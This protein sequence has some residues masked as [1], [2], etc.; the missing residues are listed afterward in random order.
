MKQPS[1]RTHA[2]DLCSQNTN[3]ADLLFQKANGV[4][5]DVQQTQTQSCF[6]SQGKGKGRNEFQPSPC[7]ALSSLSSTGL[8]QRNL[9]RSEP[10]LKH[11]MVKD[12]AQAGSLT[13]HLSG[14]KHRATGRNSKSRPPHPTAP[15]PSAAA[16]S[17]AL[18]PQAAIPDTEA[19]QPP[20]PPPNPI[21]RFSRCIILQ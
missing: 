12:D 8:P 17:A 3:A 11:P 20:T 21:P 9:L 2:A 7:Q 14:S 1:T 19:S 5:V 18:L 13:T 16:S 15:R 10:M 4:F 6:F